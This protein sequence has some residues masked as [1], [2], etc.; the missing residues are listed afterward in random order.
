[1]RKNSQHRSGGRPN[2]SDAPQRTDSFAPNTESKSVRTRR[3]N[4]DQ[5]ASEQLPSPNWQHRLLL[6]LPISQLRAG[7]WTLRRKPFVLK[8]RLRKDQLTIHLYRRKAPSWTNTAATDLKPIAADPS[9]AQRAR[10][11]RSEANPLLQ[12]R[13]QTDWDALAVFN[14]ASLILEDQTHFIYRAIGWNGESVFGHAASTDGLSM[15]ERADEPVYTDESSLFAGTGSVPQSVSDYQ[16]GISRIGCEDPR[17][18]RIDDRI[19]MTYTAFDGQHPPGVALTSIAVDDFKAK[20]WNWQAPQLI[21]EPNQAHKNWVLFPE[22][23]N[24]KYALLHGI[25]PTIQIHF[26]DAIDQPLEFPIKSHYRPSGNGGSWDNHIRG[27]GPPPIKTDS[28]WLVFYHAMDC[29]DPGRYKIGAMLLDAADP[30]IIISK[31]QYPLLQPDARYENDGL[32]QGV[33]YT[34][35]AVCTGDDIR[36]Y[37]GGADTVLCMASVNI[38]TLL[39]E[40][41]PQIL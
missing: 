14:A 26:L 5:H 1:M 39:E 25:S 2:Q 4:I 32:K 6:R 17:L 23:I 29:D 33:V 19:Y 37:Y 35:G 18:T 36:V 7:T 38:K 13:A 41:K 11:H 31:L 10:L 9:Q 12:P 34:C 28:G 16:S 8:L 24:G 27:V 21:S 40:L 30:T 22:K 3:S 20:R 15:D